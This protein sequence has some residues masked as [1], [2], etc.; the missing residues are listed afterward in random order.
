MYIKNT[1]TFEKQVL[2]QTYRLRDWFPRSFE[3]TNMTRDQSQ[4]VGLQKKPVY[5]KL[6][7]FVYFN[8]DL[9]YFLVKLKFF[10]I[11]TINFW[12]VI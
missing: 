6:E 12:T 5:L 1:T 8:A 9:Q 11:K 2:L 10:K 3:S 7:H 4:S